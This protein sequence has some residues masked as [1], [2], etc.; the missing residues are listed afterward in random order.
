MSD[1]R[2]RSPVAL[3]GLGLALVVLALLIWRSAFLIDDAYISFRYARNWAEHGVPAYNLDAQPPVE[4]YSN[5]LWVVMLRLAYGAGWSLEVT[6]QV[7]GALCGFAT[8]VV[9]HL[10]LARTLRLPPLAVALGDISLA[11]FPP[12]AVWCTGGL[13]TSLLGLLVLGSYAG[14]MRRKAGAGLPAAALGLALA[15]TRVEGFAWVLAVAACAWIA[16]PRG[17]RPSRRRRFGLFLGVYLVGFGAFLVWR[18]GVYGEWMANTVHAKAGFTGERLL[19][20]AKTSV[21]FLLLFPSAL[22]ALV[23]LVCAL[24]GE[25]RGPALGLGGL[26]LAFLGYNLLVGGDWMPFFRFLAPATPM[27]AGLLALTYA[28]L[29][30]SLALPVASAAIVA[31][32]LP[33]YDG[34]LLPRGLRVALDSREF[35]QSRDLTEWGRWQRSKQN[36]E[37]IFLPLGRALKQHFGEG[38]SL[39]FGAIGAVGWQSNLRIHDINGL[40]DREVARRGGTTSDRSA[41]H[42]KQVPRSWFVERKP[43]LFHAVLVPQAIGPEGSPGYRQALA[44]AR[45]MI[46]ARVFANPEEEVLRDLT[47]VRAYRLNADQGIPEGSLLVVLAAK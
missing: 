26:L 41:G 28:R 44:A 29:R 42:D 43:T 24:G 32:L 17:E 37:T 39:T 8:L 4:G 34:S 16:T 13:E 3:I 27:L 18:H 6:S 1:P 45:R 35:K 2:E 31:S 46:D 40:V 36:L 30:P 21:S 25:R 33:L 23:S 5:F 14:L 20:G 47:V 38:D 15:L 22:L 10:H 12:F 11:A 9:L 19:R 7:L